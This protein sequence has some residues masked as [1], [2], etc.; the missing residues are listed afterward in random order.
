M[1]FF[2][3]KIIKI[4]SKLDYLITL[5][6]SYLILRQFLYKS[7][8]SIYQ[9]QTLQVI[10]LLNL[11]NYKY[12]VVKLEIFLTARI[13]SADK[14][15]V[16]DTICLGNNIGNIY[17]LQIYNIFRNIFKALNMLYIIHFLLLNF[18]SN[19]LYFTMVLLFYYKSKQGR[20]FS[21]ITKYRSGLW[22]LQKLMAIEV[23]PRQKA[24]IITS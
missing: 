9:K 11:F 13:N 10:D 24:Y 20:I 22:S 4:N 6:F 5:F 1:K 18:I 3:K 8:F 23:N 17:K 7:N 21:N 2:Q 14:T 16:Y 19:C 12:I 15:F